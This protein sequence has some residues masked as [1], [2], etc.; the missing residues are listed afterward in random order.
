MVY[1]S[2][3]NTMSVLLIQTTTL[4]DLHSRQY[5]VQLYPRYIFLVRVNLYPVFF[6][7]T[8]SGDVNTFLLLRGTSF[9]NSP[10]EELRFNF[11]QHRKYVADL[12][13]IITNASLSYNKLP[14]LRITLVSFYL[15]NFSRG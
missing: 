8:T 2:T 4:T 1:F 5:S 15:I 6:T 7:N 9:P 13:I 3:Y 11:G 12:K 14:Q 10:D